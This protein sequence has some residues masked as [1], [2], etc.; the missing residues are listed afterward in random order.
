[1]RYVDDAVFAQF[2][3]EFLHQPQKYYRDSFNDI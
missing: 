3:S 1:M 2:L